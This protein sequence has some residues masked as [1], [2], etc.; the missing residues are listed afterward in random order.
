MRHLNSDDAEHLR[1]Y[2]DEIGASF[3]DV[4]GADNILWVE[5]QTEEK[6]F[7]LIIEHLLKHSLMGTVVKAAIATGDF[8][9]KHAE[10]FFDMYHRLS[11][12]QSLIPV[13][14]GFIFD[15]EGRTN[16]QKVDLQ[17]R[18]KN[19]LQNLGRPTSVDVVHFTRLRMY[20]NYLLE[21][22]AVTAVLNATEGHTETIAEK[23][24]EACIAR[25]LEDPSFYKPLD[26]SGGIG[27]IHG[28]RVLREVF[29]RIANLEYRK[30]THSVELTE[31]LIEHDPEKLRD[32][33][34]LIR[35]ALGW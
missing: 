35:D 13:P 4:Y 24:V 19:V 15:S 12:A 8:E 22:P 34:D 30:T 25:C 21:A 11:S 29:K 5:G 20:E 28:E 17:R 32:L 18:A 26:K 9:T 3:A 23:D 7:L 27:S 10:R 31:W 6:C 2:L 14:V 16:S 1:A 33:A